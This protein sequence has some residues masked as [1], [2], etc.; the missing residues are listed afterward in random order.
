MYW[1]QIGLISCV[2]A[3]DANIDE[4][5]GFKFRIAKIQNQVYSLWMQ[6]ILGWEDYLESIKF[7]L[8][9]IALNFAA[10]VLSARSIDL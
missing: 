10:A 2:Y 8:G 5:T 7:H 3:Q 1:I 9:C 4:Y 6:Q